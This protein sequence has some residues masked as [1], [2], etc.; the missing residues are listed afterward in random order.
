MHSH[1]GHHGVS[2]GGP[3]NDKVFTGSFPGWWCTRLGTTW[4]QARTKEEGRRRGGG[5]PARRQSSGKG[6]R[7]GGRKRSWL[8]LCGE[9]GVRR[10]PQ[11]HQDHGIHLSSGSP[12]W[13]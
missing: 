3:N 13:G 12:R 1:G 4:A 5:S 10:V 9:E 2:G 8:I 11:Q 6:W 7:C